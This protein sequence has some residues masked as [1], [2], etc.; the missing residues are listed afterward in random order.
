MSAQ[1][2]KA[3]N[4]SIDWERLARFEAHPTRVG[5]L[6]RLALL[7][8]RSLSSQELSYEVRVKTPS[9]RYHLQRLLDAGVI[10]VDF[11]QPVRAVEEHFY[12]LVGHPEKRRK[13]GSSVES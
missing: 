2:S 3:S 5:I 6:K 13:R 4:P 1:N 11:S 8:G 9:V 7:G 10:E 12:C